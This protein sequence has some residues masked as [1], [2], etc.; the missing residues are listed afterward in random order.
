MKNCIKT[1]CLLFI[2]I[3][4]K[5][6]AHNGDP[7][8]SPNDKIIYVNVLFENS[9]LIFKAPKDCNTEL[10]ASI[11]YNSNNQYFSLKTFENIQHIQIFKSNGELEYQIP[12]NNSLVHIALEDFSI[13]SYE[14]KIKL[15]S[16]RM[17]QTELTKK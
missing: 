1:L 12:I 3:S 15:D 7:V 5:A 11:S 6:T 2:L 13:G 4:F 10:L 16:E 8:E 14:V 17:I 9:S